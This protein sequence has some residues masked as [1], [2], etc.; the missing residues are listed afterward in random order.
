M[1]SNP[2]ASNIRLDFGNLPLVEAVV[3]VSFEPPLSL[4]FN[5]INGVGERLRPDFSAPIVL[6]RVET[7]PGIHEHTVQIGPGHIPGAV[8]KGN[9]DALVI[10]LQGQVIVARW[11]KATP[12]QGSEY[13][14]YP[15]LH[16]ALWRAMDALRQASNT[17]SRTTVVNM[18]YVNFLRIAHTEPVL[19]RYFSRLAHVDA[20]ANADQIHKVELAWRDDDGIDLRYKLEQVSAKIAD[21]T[22]EGYRLTTVAGVRLP[23]QTNEKARLDCVHT[24]LQTF[25]RDLISE[26]AKKEWQF[27][28]NPLG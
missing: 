19:D 9:D 2:H 6:D 20:V 14:R 3:R 21:E 28:E 16:R 18:S 26:R 4:T 13:P 15:A 11:L 27:Q 12:E 22:I 8:Y 23:D 10:T 5:I 17:P 24:R 7:A 1:T 25:F